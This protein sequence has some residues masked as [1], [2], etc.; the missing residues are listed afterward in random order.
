MRPD[1]DRPQRSSL[2]S[3]VGGPQRR[4]LPAEAT[5]VVADEAAIRCRAYELY[6]ARQQRGEAGDAAGD[7]TRAQAEWRHL[8]ARPPAV[9]GQLDRQHGRR[10]DGRGL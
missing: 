7:W 9:D 6:E 10:P 8:L 4:M 3:S 1:A 2:E 5:S